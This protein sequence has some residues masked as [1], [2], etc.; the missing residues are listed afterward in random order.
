MLEIRVDVRIKSP[1]YAHKLGVCIQP[2]YYGVDW[3]HFIYFFEYWIHEGATLFILYIE[4]Y[5]KELEFIFQ[6]YQKI[7]N[8]EIEFVNFSILPTN[9]N[10]LKQN[11]NNYVHRL[12]PHLA[13]FDCL[14]RARGRAMYVAQTD[15]DEMF[16][17]SPMILLRE[18]NFN[19]FYN[20]QLETNFTLFQ[21]NKLIYRPER[22]KKFEIH[23]KNQYE[24]DPETHKQYE[25]IIID[26]HEA[27]KLHL[28][29]DI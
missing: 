6:L 4:S 12:E 29:F 23:S 15:L 16:L 27:I 2:I 18:F 25:H 9:A 13:M 1:S 19:S 20:S 26:P 3:S 14:H 8:L 5:V 28:R 24:V 7:G 11:P 21:Y 22:V 10:N 17:N